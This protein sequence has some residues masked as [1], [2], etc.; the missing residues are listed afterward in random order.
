MCQ[1]LQDIMTAVD[2]F[3]QLCKTIGVQTAATF[4]RQLQLSSSR[5]PFG[6]PDVMKEV[7]DSRDRGGWM[8]GQ[9]QNIMTPA[10]TGVEA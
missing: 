6:L 10:F 7:G 9:A 2:V 5:S 4:D 8:D 1:A 3:L